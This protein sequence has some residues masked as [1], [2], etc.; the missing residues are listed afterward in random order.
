MLLLLSLEGFTPQ[1]YNPI[2]LDL[3]LLS[4]TLEIPQSWNGRGLR[5]GDL[6]GLIQQL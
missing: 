3:E 5:Y 2:G 6:R 1:P 4:W